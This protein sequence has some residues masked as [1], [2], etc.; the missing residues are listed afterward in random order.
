M[1]KRGTCY[2]SCQLTTFLRSTK[3]MLANRRLSS[4]NLFVQ[5]RKR[6]WK[7]LI[8]SMSRPSLRV[9]AKK[10]HLLSGRWTKRH[11]RSL[12]TRETTT[13]PYISRR[14][15]RW[16][17]IHLRRRELSLLWKIRV[18]KKSLTCLWPCMAIVCS[19]TEFPWRKRTKKKRTKRLTSA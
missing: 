12:L 4:K 2:L 5:R 16:C 3:S 13:W 10:R 1:T 19:S 15:W 8:S 14:S 17:L 7:E 6:L 18:T 9:R 11:C